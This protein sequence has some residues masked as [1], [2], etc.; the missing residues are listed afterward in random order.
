MELQEARVFKDIPSVP[1]EEASPRL[2]DGFLNTAGAV[3]TDG[4]NRR[5]L[6]RDADGYDRIL[7]GH[8]VDGF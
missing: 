7:I 3:R 6:I 8:Q 4:A 2:T 5:L 1:L